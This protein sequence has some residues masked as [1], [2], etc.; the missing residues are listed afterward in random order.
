VRVAPRGFDEIDSFAFAYL[1]VAAQK[2]L[3]DEP[4]MGATRCAEFI[5]LVFDIDRVQEQSDDL[6]S[7]RSSADVARGARVRGDRSPPPIFATP[8]RNLIE[9]ATSARADT[10]AAH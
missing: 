3:G 1:L 7:T 5:S 8:D 10:A 2:P 4:A 9:V 6:E